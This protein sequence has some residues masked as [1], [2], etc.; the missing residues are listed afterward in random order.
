LAGTNIPH[1]D[2]ADGY[3]CEGLKP[4]CVKQLTHPLLSGR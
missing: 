2:I 4:A 1:S 3:T